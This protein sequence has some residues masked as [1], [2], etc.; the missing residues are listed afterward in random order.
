[1]A[2]HLQEAMVKDHR[3]LA[4]NKDLGT[5]KV[6]HLTPS[7][8]PQDVVMARDQMEEVPVVVA[9]LVEQTAGEADLNRLTGHLINKADLMVAD[10]MEADLMEA[11]QVSVKGQTV[12]MAH[13]LLEISN[14]QAMVSQATSVKDLKA[15][16][17]LA[18]C[19]QALVLKHLVVLE[20]STATVVNH[21]R[22]M[23][24]LDLVAALVVLEVKAEEAMVVDLTMMMD[25]L[26]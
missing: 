20:D 25:N 24:F 9:A 21:H 15:G 3:A 19:H 23:V 5:F 11:V 10:L 8:V 26:M 17:T 13:R 16:Q 2:H 12:H 14:L 18:I 4:L 6:V 22:H 1:M 7:T